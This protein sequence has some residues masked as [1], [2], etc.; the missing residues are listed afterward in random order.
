M[1]KWAV[2]LIEVPLED[3]ICLLGKREK[4]KWK[5]ANIQ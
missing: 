4:M 1:S 5:R 2:A 3:W